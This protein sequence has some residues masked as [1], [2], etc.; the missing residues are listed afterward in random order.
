MPEQLPSK[1]DVWGLREEAKFEFLKKHLL[2]Q[3]SFGCSQLDKLKCLA[4]NRYHHICI[5]S[6]EYYL[7]QDVEHLDQLLRLLCIPSQSL[8]KCT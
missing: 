8:T 7:D 2:N 3:I 1:V 4:G 5:H 6:C